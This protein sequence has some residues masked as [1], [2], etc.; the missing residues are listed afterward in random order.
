MTR[1]IQR[2]ECGFEEVAST[3]S[4]A[5][6]RDMSHSYVIW[7]ILMWNDSFICDMLHT[8]IRDQTH[9]EGGKDFQQ[10]A[11]T[12]SSYATW[13]IHMRHTSYIR[14][15]T[16]EEGGSDFQQAASIPSCTI[17]RNMTHSCVALLIH[18]VVCGFH[19]GP[20]THS[21]AITCDL[22]ACHDSFRCTVLHF[23]VTWLICMWHD[24]FRG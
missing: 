10:A 14:D 6:I 24:S 18:R 1:L 16:H 8:Y 3:Y 22:C 2:V 9:S 13:P 12:P 23:H 4:S 17:I 19:E 15:Q 20:S 5:F 21:C 7:P 11:S